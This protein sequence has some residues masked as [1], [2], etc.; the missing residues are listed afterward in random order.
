MISQYQE[1]LA[2]WYPIDLEAAASEYAQKNSQ[3]RYE[4]TVQRGI[5]SFNLL[6]SQSILLNIIIYLQSYNY[7]LK[8]NLILL[9]KNPDVNSRPKIV[10][11]YY[12][13]IAPEGGK[14]LRERGK[15]IIQNVVLYFKSFAV[16]G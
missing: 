5:S 1:A 2:L 11:V 14:F 7:L 9:Y 6:F 12:K 15:I 16:L 8:F 3:Q 4:N 10:F 13:N